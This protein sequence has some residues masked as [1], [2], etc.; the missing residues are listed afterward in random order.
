[1]TTKR[2]RPPENDPIATTRSVYPHLLKRAWAVG[3]E[4]SAEDL[5]QETLIETLRRYPDYRGVVD[6]DAY[7]CTV[8]L[9]LITKG[10]LRAKRRIDREIS[11][12]SLTLG[13]GSEPDIGARL[14]GTE[15]LAQLPIRQRVCVYLSVVCELSD[16][17][18]AKMLGCRPSTVRS[19]VTRGL[20]RMKRNSASLP[21][22]EWRQHA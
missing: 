13:D 21:T 16:R 10:R 7:T 4:D 12:A 22:D 18:A 9:R 11:A 19:N 6:P 14:R 2:E 20:A 17:E 3:C 15:L 8:L 1:M 5:V